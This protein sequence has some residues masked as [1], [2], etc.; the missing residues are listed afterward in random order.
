MPAL[1]APRGCEPDAPPQELRPTTQPPR[2]A[3]VGCPPFGHPGDANSHITQPPA[4]R[5]KAAQVR[6]G[7]VPA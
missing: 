5:P 4:R 3:A 2:F 6:G 1:W 7:G